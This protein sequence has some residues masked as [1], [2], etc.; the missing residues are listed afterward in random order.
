MYINKY[1]ELWDHTCMRIEN[2]ES[3]SKN[4]EQ[5]ARQMVTRLGRITHIEKVHYAIAVL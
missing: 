2:A 5:F 4:Y 1:S 3:K